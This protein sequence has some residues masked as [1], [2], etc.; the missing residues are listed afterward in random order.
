M[1]RC[2]RNA[3]IHVL[4]HYARAFNQGE[5]R[6]YLILERFDY[7][8]NFKVSVDDESIATALNFWS[9]SRR[10][11]SI[12]ITFGCAM[13]SAADTMRWLVSYRKMASLLWP[14]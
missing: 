13:L 12:R 3:L 8:L 1:K 4:R 14:T 6:Q 11:S 10:T 2:G 7:P 5:L 9:C